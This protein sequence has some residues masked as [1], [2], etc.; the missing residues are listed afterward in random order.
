MPIP[1]SAPLRSRDAL[2]PARRICEALV[3]ANLGAIVVPA[4]VRHTA[5]Q[6]SAIA[7][8][9][10]RPGPIDHLNSAKVDIDSTVSA[11]QGITLVDDFITRGAHFLGMYPLVANAFPHQTISCFALVR[12]NSFEEVTAMIAPV[13]GTIKNHGGRPS[14][15]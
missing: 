5:V 3:A 14:R 4:L 10:Q 12:T 7:P 9:G 11:K 6:K 2:W 8:A 15:V 1:R 13:T